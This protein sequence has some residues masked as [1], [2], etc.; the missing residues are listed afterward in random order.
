MIDQV[1]LSHRIK[2]RP[3][4][5]SGGEMQR[6]AIARSLVSE[7][8]V[9]LADEPTG[10]LDVDT[11]KGIIELLQRLNTEHD[12]TILMVTHD[13]SIA[14]RAQRLVRLKKGQIEKL[15]ERAA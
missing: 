14:Q 8:Q 2:H 12:L 5:L 9:L 4:Q 1:G 10:N 7:P 11:G 3:N 15:H 6:A 13:E